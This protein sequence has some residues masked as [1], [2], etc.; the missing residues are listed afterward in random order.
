MLSEVATWW[1]SYH[2]FDLFILAPELLGL[3]D[4]LILVF[5]K[6]LQVQ[7]QRAGAH[8][9][10]RKLNS[11]SDKHAETFKTKLKAAVFTKHGLRV[12][13]A[14]VFFSARKNCQS[15]F[16]QTQQDDLIHLAVTFQHTLR[17][18]LLLSRPLMPACRM[19]AR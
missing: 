18:R 8:V 10:A 4:P 15:Y 11:S 1:R 13:R 9:S 17:K 6:S 19:R 5:W 12:A 14:A 16:D 2:L 7:L 3:V